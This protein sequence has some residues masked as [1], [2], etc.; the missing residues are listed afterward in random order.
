MWESTGYYYGKM[1][2]RI[3]MDLLGAVPRKVFYGEMKTWKSKEN[4]M[5][6]AALD[7]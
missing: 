5:I 2:Q 6:S 4:P 3:I 1:K 7:S